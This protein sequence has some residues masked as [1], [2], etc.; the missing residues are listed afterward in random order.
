MMIA[1]LDALKT[2]EA[3]GKIKM[4]SYCKFD[5]YYVFSGAKPDEKLYG[6]VFVTVNM[7]TGETGLIADSDLHNIKWLPTED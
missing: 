5:R 7:Q 3:F 2:A 4:R 6:A 1:F